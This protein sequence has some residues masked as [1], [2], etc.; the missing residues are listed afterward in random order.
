MSKLNPQA[1]LT[2][3]SMKQGDCLHLQKLKEKKI[4]IF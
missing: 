1:L 4:H 3:S 2:L